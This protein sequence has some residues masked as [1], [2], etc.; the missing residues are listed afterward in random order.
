MGNGYDVS[1]NSSMTQAMI[2][3]IQRHYIGDQDT[4]AL[5]D[6]INFNKET[7]SKQQI[8]IQELLT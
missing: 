3:V 7:D 6:N 8:V 4:I 5:R 1:D 2:M